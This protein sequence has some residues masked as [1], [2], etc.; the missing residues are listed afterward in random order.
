NGSVSDPAKQDLIQI[1]LKRRYTNAAETAIAGRIIQRNSSA[2]QRILLRSG[3]GVQLTDFKNHNVIL[4]GSPTSN[5]WSRLF[6]EKL[7]FQFEWDQVR[8]GLFRNRSPR[9]GEKSVYS[10]TTNP[11]ESG[12]A[13]A[14]VAFVPNVNSEG[15]V[16]LINGTT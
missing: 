9:A 1:L 8:R 16:L 10:M 14:V 7:N 2:S 11:G 4:F 12:E 13:Y 3:R 6:S 15:H 5:P